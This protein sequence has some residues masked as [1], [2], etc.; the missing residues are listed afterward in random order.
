MQPVID[1]DVLRAMPKV[2]LHC[3]LEGSLRAST[4]ADLAEHHGIDLPVADPA[5]LYQ[6]ADLAGFL[7]A[8]EI[9]CRV[10]VTASDFA[11]VTYESLE[12]AAMTSNV[13]YREMFFN[14]TLHPGVSYPDM[15]TGI[16]DGVR[17]AEHDYGIV[18]RLIPSIY[19]QMPVAAAVEM[20][21]LVVAHRDERVVGIGMDGDELR[22]PP[23]RFAAA[24]AAAA[25]AGLHRTAHVAHD[26]PASFIRTC[27]DVLG[28]ER[29]DHGYHVVDDPALM[30]ELRERRVPFLCATPTPPLCGWPSGLDESPVR[31]MIDAG[32]VV[33]VN[34]DDP[35]ML[36]TD[37]ATEFEKVCNGWRLG[38][39]RTKQLVMD[40]IAAAWCDETDRRHLATT[41]SAELDDVLGLTEG[42]LDG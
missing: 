16:L 18:T 34:S 7:G 6:Y 27:L 9:A 5:D 30:D 2:E 39:H 8:Y 12:D 36:H 19:R 11:L 15:L 35:T 26:A 28:C 31:T 38:P 1:R 40:A 3:H 37:L 22:D 21:D 10:L 29:V 17:A 41:I 24:Y 14:P 42:A 4:V 23:E 32:L 20:V 25:A 33:V 13:R